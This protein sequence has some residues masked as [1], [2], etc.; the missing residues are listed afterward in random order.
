MTF[1]RIKT[2][3]FKY[4]RSYVVPRDSVGRLDKIAIELFGN[5]RFYKPLAAANNIRMAL[6]S[7][8]GLRPLND[9]IRYDLVK[10]D[11]KNIDSVLID[12]IDSHVVSDNDW[13]YYGDTQT[14][15]FTELTL[16]RLLY[17]P[18]LE[19]ALDWLNKYE[20]MVK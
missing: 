10:A 20:Y 5:E 12:V 13:N 11:V 6:F 4:D 16:G 1:P 18:S 17:V 15:L 3:K 19:S 9:A 2:F 8:P 14:G 7:R